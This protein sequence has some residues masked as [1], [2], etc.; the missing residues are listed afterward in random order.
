M[1]EGSLARAVNEGVGLGWTLEHVQFA[2]RESSKRPAMAFVFFVREGEPVPVRTAEEA[3]SHLR[4]LA[5]G[6]GPDSVS[7]PAPL[8]AVSP[9]DRLRELAGD[10]EGS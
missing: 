4:R 8:R 5:V 6:D 9:I 3:T 7:G 10:E 2:M 1:D